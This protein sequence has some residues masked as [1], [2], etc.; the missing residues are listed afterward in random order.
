VKATI[1]SVGSFALLVGRVTSFFVVAL[2]SVFNIV[3]GINLVIVD[4][5]FNADVWTFSDVIGVCVDLYCNGVTGMLIVVLGFVLNVSKLDTEKVGL[6]CSVEI[7]LLPSLVGITVVSVGNFV[8]CIVKEVVFF[9]VPLNAVD[10]LGNIV[11][12]TIGS[13]GSFALLVG[14]VT[15][16]FVVALISVFN[17][18][19]GITLVIVDF[20]F[21]ADVWTFSDVIG[22]C[23]DLYSNGVTGMLIVVLG[24]VLNVSKMDTE[25]VG[26]TCSVEIL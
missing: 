14:R 4:F 6:T 11:K 12:A 8:V 26:L 1:G 5:A 24:F 20:A 18:V 19:V 9:T 23:V 3:V 13:V 2:I 22:V 17:I 15:S 21:N 10:I 16:F 25:T 7:L